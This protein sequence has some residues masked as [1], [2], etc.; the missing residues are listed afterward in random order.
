MVYEPKEPTDA[1]AEANR[2]ALARQAMDD[3]ADFEDIERGLI[4]RIGKTLTADGEVVFDFATVQDMAPGQERPDSVNPSLWRQSQLNSVGGLFKVTD[5]LYQARGSGAANLTIV[6]GPEGLVIIDCTASTDSA[7]QGLELFREHVS[8]KPV[9][10]VIYTHTHFDHY[11]GVK[12][13]IDPADV[14]SGKVPIIAPG[15][16]ASFDKRAKLRASRVRAPRSVCKPP[17]TRVTPVSVIERVPAARLL[18][19]QITPPRAPRLRRPPGPG[20]SQKVRQDPGGSPRRP[21]GLADRWSPGIFV[22]ISIML[23]LVPDCQI[24]ARNPLGLSCRADVVSGRDCNIARCSRTR[25][26]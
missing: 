7:R 10:A 18:Q 26:S 20:L 4:A 8:D 12:G 5:G 25:R 22:D 13:V 17:S 15:T 14:A 3:R 2:A 1:T 9:V 16:I 24:G 21:Q 6:D 23:L 19:G 11:G